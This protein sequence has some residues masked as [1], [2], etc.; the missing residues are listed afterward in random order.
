MACAEWGDVLEF[1]RGE[2]I[3]SDP[4]DLP[5]LAAI[6]RRRECGL[7]LVLEILKR[8]DIAC[9][10]PRRSGNGAREGGRADGHAALLQALVDR[11][12]AGAY[13]ITHGDQPI[14]PGQPTRIQAELIDASPDWRLPRALVDEAEAAAQAAARVWTGSEMRTPSNRLRLDSGAV[15][16]LAGLFIWLR[17][18]SARRAAPAVAQPERDSL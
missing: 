1:Y 8:L 12:Q 7:G 4:R 15:H 3:G 5:I 13:T 6:T 18:A 14:A 2:S 9:H 16:P 17:R 10:G 11:L